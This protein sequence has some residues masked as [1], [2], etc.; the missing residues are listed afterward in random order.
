MKQLVVQL[1]VHYSTIDRI[2]KITGKKIT[3]G[4]DKLINEALDI[5]E[6]ANQEDDVVAGTKGE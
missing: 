6:R 2:E 5:L 1:V 3:K 4:G